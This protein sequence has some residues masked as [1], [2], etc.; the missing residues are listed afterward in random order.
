MLQLAAGAGIP[1][2]RAGLQPTDD[3]S[4]GEVLAGPYHPAF[5][6]LADGERWYDLLQLLCAG[7]EGGDEL[8]ISVAPGRVSEVTGQ[9]RINFRRIEATYPLRL[10]RVHGDP[11]LG[12]DDMVITGRSSTI[13]ANLLR[14]LRYNSSMHA[15]KEIA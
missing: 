2:I 4:S 5:R 15:V 14:D 6:Q 3:L 8:E 13:N 9:K 7:F 10:R 12:R 1:V 11:S